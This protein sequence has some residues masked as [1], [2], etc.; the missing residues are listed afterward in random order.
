MNRRRFLSWLAATLSGAALAK[1]GGGRHR[2]NVAAIQMAPEL[3]N[4]TANRA[5]AE[6]LVLEALRAGAELVLL[7]EFFTS[8]AAFHPSMLG[9]IEPFDGPSLRMLKGLARSGDAVVGGSFLALDGG[10][11]FNRF[12][13]AF[14]DGQVFQHDKDDPTFWE[15][16]YYRSGSDDGLLQTP[17]GPMGVALCWELIRRRTAERLRGRV[18]LN[19]AASNWWT[20]P[21]EAELDSPMWSAN[22]QMLREAPGSFAR[23]TGAPVIHASHAARFSAFFSP[24]LPDVPYESSFLGE[25]CITD[26]AG[27]VIARRP[28][29]AG[30]GVVLADIEIGP[31]APSDALPDRF[32]LPEEMPETWSESWGRWLETG[33]DYYAEVTQPFIGT[34]EIRE[35]APPYLR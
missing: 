30:A 19:L 29:E 9:A 27:K 35:Y 33:A 21:D 8:A 15:A 4:V 22:L 25:S 11:V 16:C 5:Q 13:L 1:P 20:L 10:Q 18:V 6:S 24:E 12:V 2:V 26:A 28:G 14:P 23:L 7:P 3:G 34:G 32:W 31:V 17:L